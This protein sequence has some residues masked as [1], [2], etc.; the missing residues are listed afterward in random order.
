MDR[1]SLSSLPF[2]V[3]RLKHVDDA[4]VT[5]L[6]L[7]RVHL[8]C[9][10]QHDTRWTLWC[11]FWIWTL[12]D[13]VGQGSF[14]PFFADLKSGNGKT[15]VHMMVTQLGRVSIALQARLGSLSFALWLVGVVNCLLIFRGHFLV[16]WFLC[17]RAGP[18]FVSASLI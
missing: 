15:I 17:L 10:P 7:D 16:P 14:D 18:N 2:W 1:I 11:S 12:F 5:L 4:S 9:V 8:L 6:F 3:R 13:A